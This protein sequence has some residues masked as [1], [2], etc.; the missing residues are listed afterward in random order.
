MYTPMSTL[1]YI[2]LVRLDVGRLRFPSHP[3]M[4]TRPPGSRALGAGRPCQRMSGV[5]S[6]LEATPHLTLFTHIFYF[7]HWASFVLIAYD[8][9]Y[10][11]NAA[12]ES[13]AA[14]ADKPFQL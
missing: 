4:D 5:G 2:Y 9:F 12:G 13:T 6:P 7:H 8:V 14:K 10:A 11:P 3:P 1:N